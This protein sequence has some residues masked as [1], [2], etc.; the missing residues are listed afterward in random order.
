VSDPHRALVALTLAACMALPACGTDGSSG[1]GTV[2][3]ATGSVTAESA[4]RAVLA[5][6]EIADE[7]DPDAAAAPF[8][9]RAHATLH[10]IAAAVGE[11]DRGLEAALLAAKSRVEADLERDALPEGFGADVSE[12]IAATGDALEALGLPTPPCP[13]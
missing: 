12:L 4:N 2:P 13:A 3:R 1:G 7:T 9:D 5:L 11:V 10:L 6:C 8:H